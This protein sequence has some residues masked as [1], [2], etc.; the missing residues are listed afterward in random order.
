MLDV[1]AD[2]DLID[3]AV[4]AVTDRHGSLRGEQQAEVAAIDVKLAANEAA[5]DRYLSSFEAGSMPESVAGARVTALA[6]T[7][8]ALRHR[9]D[10]LQAILDLAGPQTPD[11][12]QLAA[13]RDEITEAIR[14]A[15]TRVIKP[16]VETL[17]HEIRIHGR[18]HIQPTFRLPAGA[19]LKPG[20][21]VREMTGTVLPTGLEPVCGGQ[22]CQRDARQMGNRSMCNSRR[23]ECSPAR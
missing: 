12:A 16:V 23:A 3:Q 2:T 7:N 8:T 4:A 15:D 17:V 22:R 10:E 6:D 11:P 13:L 5:I 9:R 1:Y 20:S 14:G 19:T 18:G 21:R